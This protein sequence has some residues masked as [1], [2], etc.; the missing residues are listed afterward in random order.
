MY[1]LWTLRICRAIHH[2]QKKKTHKIK[3]KVF[4][5][6]AKIKLSMMNWDKKIRCQTLNTE[7]RL[8][9]ST[10]STQTRKNANKFHQT[11][12]IQIPNRI[13]LNLE[14]SNKINLKY[15]MTMNMNSKIGAKSI[16]LIELNKI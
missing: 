1:H 11:L 12:V 14:A 2:H 9:I 3:R 8:I 5:L 13:S 16:R 6:T 10:T 7:N 4:L 15:I